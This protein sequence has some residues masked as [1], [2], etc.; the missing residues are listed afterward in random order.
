MGVLYR[1]K[2][3]RLRRLA[4]TG[5]TS[6]TTYVPVGD[7]IGN[8]SRQFLM[9][10]LTDVGLIFTLDYNPTYPNALAEDASG[11]G[12]PDEIYVPSGGFFL[13]DV[14]SNLGYP[15]GNYIAAGAYFGVRADSTLPSMGQVCITVSHTG[16]IQ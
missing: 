12:T 4:Y 7:P 8:E 3:D 11:N 14:T 6:N 9:Q 13:S 10:N 5:I 1:Y 2:L 16:G 15:S